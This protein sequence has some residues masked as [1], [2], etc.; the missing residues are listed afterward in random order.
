[1]HILSKYFNAL[2]IPDPRPDLECVRKI[3]CRHPAIF[4]FTSI[5]VLL[6]SP[7]PLDPHSLIEKIVVAG[8]GGY[9]FE[10]NKLLF[11]ALQ[12]LQLNVIPLLARIRHN[13]PEI[14][15]LTHRVTILRL[16][17]TEYLL[18][19][20]NGYLTPNLPLP[21]DGSSHRTAT[22]QIYRIRETT[23]DNYNLELLQS[24][25]EPYIVYT[26]SKQ[27]YYEPDFEL[28]HY[29]SS[30]HPQAVF[31]NNLVLTKILPECII[32]LRNGIYYKISSQKSEKNLITDQAHFTAILRDDFKYPT[33]D[34]EILI[35][36]KDFIQQ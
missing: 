1:M 27:P 9:C 24:S 32:S 4:P 19:V 13:C 21:L 25:E 28:S 5:P 12:E 10:H 30:K 23:A 16:G 35:L 31:V 22:G 3:T 14:T 2:E 7:L 11:L 36:F 26:F 34:T 18:D 20:G 29:Y 33:S 17:S 15:P 6:H 8:K